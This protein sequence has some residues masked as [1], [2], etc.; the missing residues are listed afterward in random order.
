MK[1]IKKANGK[2]A[3]QMTKAEWLKI[4]Q[5]L[6]MP[7]A[8]GMGGGMSGGMGGGMGDS[9][10]P[11]LPDTST[12]DPFAAAEGG[13]LGDVGGDLGDAGEEPVAKIRRLV[14]E[15][16]SALDEL[17]GGGVGDELGGD[18]GGDELGEDLSADFDPTAGEAD[19]GLGANPADQVV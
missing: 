13:S 7:S 16:Q 11:E 19:A 4:G 12:E 14:G 18:L 15:L 10:S 5:A 17:D 1:V 6:G 2:Q 3:V 8:G 9:P